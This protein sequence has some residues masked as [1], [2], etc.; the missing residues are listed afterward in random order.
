MET[1][2]P[3]SYS[4]IS[5]FSLLRNWLFNPLGVDSAVEAG[6]HRVTTSFPNTTSDATLLEQMVDIFELETFCLW[7]EEKDDRNL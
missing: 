5:I 2:I 6:R 3:A 1:I 7:E 4:Y